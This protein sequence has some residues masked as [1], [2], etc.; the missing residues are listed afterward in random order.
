MNILKNITG[1]YC[2]VALVPSDD[3]QGI[4]QS[5]YVKSVDTQK[6]IIILENQN[7]MVQL[8]FHHIRAVKKIE[9]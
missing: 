7:G 6:K 5:G 1:S 4:V 3:S 8:P 9:I 2:K